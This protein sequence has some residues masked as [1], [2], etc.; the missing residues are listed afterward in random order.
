MAAMNLRKA[1]GVKLD[2]P[3]AE[4]IRQN[5]DERIAE[6]QQLPGAGLVGLGQ[7]QLV[8]SVETT[9]PNPLNRKPT[10]VIVSPPRGAVTTGRIEEVRD[11]KY[12]R[13]RILVLK[14][15]GWGASIFVDVAVF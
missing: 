13:T 7:F 3:D 14:A 4:R 8:D 12:D 10:Q 11:G 5:H 9:I 15:T 2:D 6:L 1:I